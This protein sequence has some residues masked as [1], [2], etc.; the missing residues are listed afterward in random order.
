MQNLLESVRAE[1]AKYGARMTDDQCAELCNA[2]AWRHRGEGWGTSR[3]VSGTRGRLPNGQE[4][5][6]DI[7]HYAPSNELVDILTAAGAE[8]QPTWTPVGPPQ[9]A[10]RTW[11]APVDPATWSAPPAPPVVVP[12]VPAG[13]SVADVLD[14]VTALRAEVQRLHARLDAGLPLR[15]KAGFL[16]TLTGTVGRD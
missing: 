10:D 6:H 5:A 1:R 3:K 4:I 15:V 7:L 11:V 13:P 16:G 2:V 8:S 9:S 12:T 14:V